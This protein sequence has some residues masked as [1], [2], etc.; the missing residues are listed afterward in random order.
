MSLFMFLYPILGGCSTS[1]ES[2][3]LINSEPTA[4]ITS[5]TSGEEIMEGY[6]STFLGLVSDLNH[7]TTELR[8]KWSSDVRELCPETTP[9]ADGTTSCRIALESSDTMVKL[10][11]VDPDGAAG[12]STVDLVVLPTEA[13]QVQIV[14]PTVGGNYYSDQLILFSALIGDSED[15]PADLSYTWNS[16]LDGELAITAIPESSGEIEQYFNLTEGQHALSLTVEDT[17]GKI[18][19]ETV[20]ITVGGLNSE[21]SCSITS[22]QDGLAYALGDTISFAGS[23]VDEDINNSLLIVSWES[24]QDGVFNNN[25][26]DTDG[27][28]GFQYSDLS[29]GNHTIS[30]RVEDEVGALCQTSVQLSVGTPPSLSVTAPLD[31]DLYTSNESILFTATVS[32]QEELPSNLSLSWESDVDGVF[33]NQGSDSNGNISFAV[34]SLRSGPHNIFVTAIDSMG[35]S[36]SASFSLMI[37]T[38]P[39]APNVSLSPNPADSNDDIT[40]VASGSIDEDGDGI[41]YG[42]AWYQN[43][44]LTS[45]TSDVL[46]SS[47]TAIGDVWTVRVTPNDGWNDGSYAEASITIQDSAPQFDVPAS[48]SPNAGVYTNTVLTCSASASDLDDGVLTVVYEWTVNGTT[49]ASGTGYTVSATDSNVGDTIVCTASATDSQGET[50]SS[51]ASVVVLNTDPVLS[52]PSVSPSSAYNDETLLCSAT[53][54]DPDETLAVNYSWSIASATISTG[55]SLDLATTPAIPGD[56]ITCEADATDSAGVSVSGSSTA[57]VLNRAPSAP[58]VGIYPSSPSAGIDD[59]LCEVSIASADPD[60]DNVTYTISWLVNG[61]P[62]TGAQTTSMLGDTVPAS[63]TANGDTWS[64]SITPSDGMD[65]GTAGEASVVF[66]PESC[67]VDF[68]AAWSSLGQGANPENYYGSYGLSFNN[69]NGYGLIGGMGNGDPG[70][71]DID[72]SNGTAAWGCWGGDRSIS[73]DAPVTAVSLDFLRGFN[74]YSVSVDAYI[75]GSFVDSQTVSL[76]GAFAVGSVSFTGPLDELRW[77][78]GCCYGVDNL[79][80]STTDFA[81]P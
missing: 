15:E 28:I 51:S 40:A 74:D 27:S 1:E 65:D 34:S 70:N 43:S 36:T 75:G 13:P 77:S 10:Q 64:C 80:Y 79:E 76:S 44:T 32:D 62:Y 30:L 54:S 25:P 39:T 24:D 6:E 72:G 19:T 71:W 2:I 23:V 21:P 33:S 55:A 5:H 29:V 12:V 53:V 26:A 45:Y 59:L 52:G 58:S 78:A 20:A 18:S 22:P 35:L 57:T 69:T 11:V 46:S 38:P 8:V 41:S 73:F 31:G 56:V 16:N 61:N 47:A 14:S 50:A 68:D 63:D 81:C 7:N 37:N 48:I 17:S 4:T 3:K 42:Y 66:A 49:V 9:D 67:V 60:G